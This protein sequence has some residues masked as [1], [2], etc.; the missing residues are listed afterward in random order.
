VGSL[1]FVDETFAL[2]LESDFFGNGRGGGD[3]NPVQ[4][5]QASYFQPLASTHRIANWGQKGTRVS[6]GGFGL[7]CYP[8]IYRAERE[9][10]SRGNYVR[11]SGC[12][13]RGISPASWFHPFC[14]SRLYA[15]RQRVRKTRAE[16]VPPCAVAF[17]VEIGVAEMKCSVASGVSTFPNQMELTKSWKGARVSLA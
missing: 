9:R 12:P 13:L 7:L 8:Y 6:F 4:I 16:R 17:K 15:C 3:R 1:N 10:A 5:P 11:S 14:K 2:I